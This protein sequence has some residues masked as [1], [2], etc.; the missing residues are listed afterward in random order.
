MIGV[1]VFPPFASRPISILVEG[2]AD[3]DP[4]GSDFEFKI[5]LDRAVNS[6]NLIQTQIK[7]QAAL[8]FLDGNQLKRLSFPA[9]AAWGQA[10]SVVMHPVTE[11]DRQANR[12]VDVTYIVGPPGLPLKPQRFRQDSIL[13]SFKM[14]LRMGRFVGY[15]DA[16]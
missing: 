11:E 4:Q 5:S 14:N 3:R 9:T 15:V 2:Y 7:T 16:Y 6:L 8:T 13:K 10:D 12:R 1:L